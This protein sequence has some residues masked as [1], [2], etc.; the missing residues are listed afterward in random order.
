MERVVSKVAPQMF[1]GCG[2]IGSV[3]AAFTFEVEDLLRRGTL[4]TLLSLIT[5]RLFVFF[6]EIV[7][8]RTF[9]VGLRHGGYLRGRDKRRRFV[10]DESWEWK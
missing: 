3:E 7:L 10:Q 9:S 5:R 4:D 8:I 6:H 1:E 2:A